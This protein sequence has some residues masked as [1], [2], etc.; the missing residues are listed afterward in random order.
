MQWF[1]ICHD[2]VGELGSLPAYFMRTLHNCIQLEDQLGWELHI[3]LT[4]RSG[5]FL[6]VSCGV[7][8]SFHAASHPSI[9]LDWTPFVTVFTSITLY[10]SL[11]DT[12]RLSGWEIDYSSRWEILPRI[13]GCIY[14]HPSSG[15]NY[16][17]FSIMH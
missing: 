12:P 4:H 1:T 16:W 5:V 13:C 14:S 17:H 15:H 8:V 6:A 3:E 10:W 9:R 2:S 11:Q 7:S